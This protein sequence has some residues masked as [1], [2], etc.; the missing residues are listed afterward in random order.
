MGTIPLSKKAFL[1]NKMFILI[2]WSA[3]Y[4]KQFWFNSESFQPCKI[5]RSITAKPNHPLDWKKRMG[6]RRG[7]AVVVNLYWVSKASREDI[8][9]VISCDAQLLDQSMEH[10]AFDS[11]WHVLLLW[12]LRDFKEELECDIQ[13]SGDTNRAWRI[14]ICPGRGK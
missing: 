10:N 7:R 5:V 4:H 12:C 2:Q 3:V 14:Q 9:G 6:S 8:W 13:C 11:H 1:W